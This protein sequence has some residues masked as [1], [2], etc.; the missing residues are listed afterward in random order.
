M[1]ACQDA[2]K[3]STPMAKKQKRVLEHEAV[4]R[5]KMKCAFQ[6]EQ[7]ATVFRAEVYAILRAATKMI[8]KRLEGRRIAICSASQAA[9]SSPLITSKIIQGCRNR[10]NPVCRFNMV[11]LLPAPDHCGVEGNEN[12]ASTKE[13]SI[14]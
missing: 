12:L 4:S 7:Y 1:N 13:G 6:L 3:S 2:R 5:I 10:L 9:L 14:G 8:H 11:E